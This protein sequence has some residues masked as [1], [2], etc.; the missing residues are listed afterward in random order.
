MRIREAT[1]PVRER[2]VRDRLG[3]LVVGM[4]LASVACGGTRDA[5]QE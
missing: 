1:G 3:V 5:G 4:S 2:S